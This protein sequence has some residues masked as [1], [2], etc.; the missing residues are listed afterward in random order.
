M[1]AMSRISFK[2]KKY[3]GLLAYSG[4]RQL[5]SASGGANDF[6]SIMLEENVVS[7]Q[8]HPTGLP[9]KPSGRY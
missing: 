6:G 5:K 1:I 3:T 8:V 4:K 9:V 7:A 2:H